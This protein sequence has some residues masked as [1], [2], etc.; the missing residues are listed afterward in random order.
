MNGVI[1]IH[2]AM[3]CTWPV[4]AP[5]LCDCISEWGTHVWEI[6]VC[7]TEEHINTRDNS[8]LEG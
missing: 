1:F 3:L 8:C 4:A 7:C 5:F 6:T 2:N